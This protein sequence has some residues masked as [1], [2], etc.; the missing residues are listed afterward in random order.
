MRH[1][2]LEPDLDPATA[3]FEAGGSGHALRI[4]LIALIAVAAAVLAATAGWVI[5]QHGSSS[6][7]VASSSVDA[8]FARD[9]ST[10]HQQAVTM[11]IYERQYTT[12]PDLHLLAYDIEDTQTFQIGQ[13][14]GWLDTWNLY[15]NDA[16]P[17][18]WMGSAH[19]AHVV[20]GLMPGMATPAQMDKLESLRG[21][22]L[23]I[24]FLQL[25][26]HHHQGG[27]PMA[28]YALQHATQPYVRT[29][30]Q[31][32]VSTQNAEIIQ[33]ERTL[34]E[35]GGTPLPAPVS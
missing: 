5:G 18:A 24:M 7:A 14:Q 9:M 28:E 22:A 2:V 16:H 33:M 30:A 35:L 10:H 19:S 4:A 13:M 32:M 27:V 11:A 15:R 17:M 25:M 8:G 31:Q 29:L 23:D 12:D 1:D 21:K 26:I 6:T 20:N 3:E 34:R